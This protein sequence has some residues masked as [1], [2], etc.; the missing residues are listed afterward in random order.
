MVWPRAG[1]Q[2]DQDA[3][4]DGEAV[5]AVGAGAP[6]VERV[7]CGASAARLGQRGA[8][9]VRHA[10]PSSLPALLPPAL[11]CPAAARDAL[12]EIPPPM[13]ARGPARARAAGQLLRGGPG[14]RG[15][16]RARR[17]TAARGRGQGHGRCRAPATAASRR[18]RDQRPSRAGARAGRH[19]AEP[20]T[21]QRPL[22]SHLRRRNAD[23][24]GRLWRGLQG[25]AP[26]GGR[27]VRRQAGRRGGS[28]GQ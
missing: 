8:R 3:S 28:G 12:R 19:G 7:V 25:K 2:L 22:C 23:R 13:A 6:A 15:R 18:G 10:R 1:P 21:A 14:R 17:A 9:A 16:S 20:L 24:R 27:L 4:T 5:A 26:A 11:G